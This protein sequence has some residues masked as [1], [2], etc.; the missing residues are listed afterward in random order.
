MPEKPLLEDNKLPE[1][2]ADERF[3]RLVGNLVNTPHKPHE[4]REKRGPKPAPSKD[5]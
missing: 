1:P 2:E 3:R 4:S 5:R